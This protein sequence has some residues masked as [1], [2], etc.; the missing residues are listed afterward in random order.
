MRGLEL[1][2]EGLRGVQG[3]NQPAGAMMPAERGGCQTLSLDDTP[4]CC[5]CNCCIW[6]VLAFV[7]T[8][9]CICNKRMCMGFV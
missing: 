3:F 5:I 1:G 2:R 8:D 9:C 7:C 6:G 4:D